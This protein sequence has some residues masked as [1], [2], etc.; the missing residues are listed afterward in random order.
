MYLSKLQFHFDGSFA[1]H[2]GAPHASNRSYRL[3]VAV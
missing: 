2:W 3:F 1:R